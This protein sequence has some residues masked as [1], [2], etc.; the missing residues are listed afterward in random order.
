MPTRPEI[1]LLAE[2]RG[3]TRK[4]NWWQAAPMYRL[5]VTK[6]HMQFAAV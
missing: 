6:L 3:A 4:R 5:W 2:A 1:Q